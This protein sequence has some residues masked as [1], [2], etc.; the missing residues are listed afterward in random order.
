MKSAKELLTLGKKMLNQARD[1]IKEEKAKQFK[2]EAKRVL[3]ELDS[4]KRTV[5][6]LERQVA[7]LVRKFDT[8]E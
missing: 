7:N 5:I 4:A 3:L 6:L 2:E 8:N 1:E